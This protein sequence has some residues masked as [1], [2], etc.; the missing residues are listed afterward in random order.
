M[1][2]DYAV[3]DWEVADYQTYPLDPCVL[4]PVTGAPLVL[5]GPRPE[6]LDTGEYLSCIGG[7]QTFGRF[8]EEPFPVILRNKLGVPV[9]NLGRGGAGPAFFS[10][11]ND[12]VLEYVNRGRLAIIQIMSGR[13]ASNS[14]YESRGLGHYRR[15][16]DGSAIG[17]DEAFKSLLRERSPEFVNRIVAETR[18]NWVDEYRKLLKKIRVP[19]ILFWFSTR[20]PYY[21]QNSQTLD[22][23]YG[24]FPQLV[25]P[26]MIEAI[27]PYADA[28]VE[29]VSSKGLPQRLRS[30]KT[31]QPVTI[32]DPWGGRW[33]ENWYYPSPQMHA[34]AAG[35]LES[36]CRKFLNV[37]PRCDRNSEDQ[38]S[39]KQFGRLHFTPLQKVTGFFAGHKDY[40]RFFILSRGRSGSN[41]L[42]GLLNSHS[43]VVVFGEIF[44]T[45]DSIGWEFPE[46]ERLYHTPRLVTL[47]Q[48]HP[49]RFL[50]RC[51]FG[52]FPKS[53][54]AVGFKL[55]YYHAQ[56]ESR[57]A[58][59]RFLENQTAWR[60]IHLKRNSALRVL[61]SEKRAFETNRWTNTTGDPEEPFSI[62]L[63]YDECL[64][65]FV[66]NDEEKR[67]F[68]SWLGDRPKLEVF[69]EDLV[70]N[71]SRE[72]VRVQEF[73]GVEC[74]RVV[75]STYKQSNQKLSESI[76]NYYE[77]KERFSATPWETYFED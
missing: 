52:R 41:Y 62:R 64:K 57:R 35:A 68:D 28:Y 46:Y 55:F 38:K 15:R 48:R 27:R 75:P 10:Q 40:Q 63:D 2:A 76:S 33:T 9:L 31:R 60:V 58:L 12:R 22:T 5:R 32:E 29:C 30:R 36:V 1:T 3:T 42:R 50:N 24:A 14:I 39:P 44:R 43:Q 7:A 8:C 69:Y 18:E 61:L 73:L 16:S 54:H 13:S 11:N 45:Y 65:I 49:V 25:C 66:R 34:A 26:W 74:Q 37:P 59:W 70:A 71:Q 56:D 51:V 19:K 72:M 4:D 53:I 47:M 23:L 77:L 20:R 67:R 17:C 6:H 21:P